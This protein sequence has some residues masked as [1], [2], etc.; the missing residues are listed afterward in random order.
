VAAVYIDTS[1]LAKWYLNERRAD[2]F[3]SWIQ[4]QEE[5]CISSLTIVEFRCLLA[6]RRRAGELAVELEQGIF[7]TFKLDIQNNHLL[8]YPVT[9]QHISGA[10]YLMESLPGVALRTL[11]AIHL[12]IAVDLATNRLATADRIMAEAALRLGLSVERFD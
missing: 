5:A 6:R 7:A 4:D 3:A 1:A 9:D 11:D 2:E 8:G 10:A 12:N